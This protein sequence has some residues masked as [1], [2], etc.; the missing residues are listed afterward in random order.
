MGITSPVP[1]TILSDHLNPFFN[2]LSD[3]VPVPL[4]NIPASGALNYILWAMELFNPTFAFGL[5]RQVYIRTVGGVGFIKDLYTG[6]A[7]LTFEEMSGNRMGF[8]NTSGGALSIGT[9]AVRKF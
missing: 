7:G 1:T 2:I 4:F 9:T 5:V 3:G 6:P 8:T